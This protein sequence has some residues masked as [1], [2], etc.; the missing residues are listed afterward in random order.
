MAKFQLFVASLCVSSVL[1]SPWA[2]NQKR[3]DGWGTQTGG[4]EHATGG[5]EG[6]GSQ[7]WGYGETSSE[8]SPWG[9]GTTET[10]EAS[11]V[12]ETQGASTVTVTQVSTSVLTSVASGEVS[13]VTLPGSVTTIYQSG[14]ETTVTLPG[15]TYTSTVIH[16][17]P[18]SAS[19]VG[20]VT[21]CAS[22]VTQTSYITKSAQG[23][24]VT[25]TETSVVTVPGRTITAYE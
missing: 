19:Q 23:Y 6:N 2:R 25:A 5:P 3:G 15:V 22:T 20:P 16:S 17:A 7:P 9:Y 13:T 14:S 18:C 11:T 12:F 1:A 10:C 8:T 21:E 24:N 4:H